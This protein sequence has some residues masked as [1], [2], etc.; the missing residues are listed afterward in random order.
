MTDW[1]KIFNK[2]NWTKNVLG[3]KKKSYIENQEKKKRKNEW[4]NG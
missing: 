2:E 1:K 3:K 4:L